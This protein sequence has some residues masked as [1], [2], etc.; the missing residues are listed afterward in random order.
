VEIVMKLIGRAILLCVIALIVTVTAFSQRR[1]TPS[2]R[3]E[4]SYDD[5]T[6]GKASG[7]LEGMRV[8]LVDGGGGIY[9]IVQ[10]AAGGVELPEPALTE[11]TV[12]GTDISFSIKF[13][14]QDETQTFSGR[15]SASGIRLRRGPPG[16]A[17]K[18]FFLKRRKC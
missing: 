17:P 16:S 18:P 15:V 6:V 5:L 2:V 8:I 12:K 11:V 9:A 4:G 1:G 7:D 10:E 3:I 13:P 14:R